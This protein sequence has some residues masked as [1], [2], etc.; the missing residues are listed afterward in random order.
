MHIFSN[1]RL[2]LWNFKLKKKNFAIQTKFP[3]HQHFCICSRLTNLSSIIPLNVDTV[4]RKLQVLNYNRQNLLIDL[5]KL[6]ITGH[7]MSANPDIF[8]HFQLYLLSYLHL[9]LKEFHPYFLETILC[10][11]VFESSFFYK[12][13][14]YRYC[15]FLIL[16][17]YLIPQFCI[18]WRDIKVVSTKFLLKFN[19]VLELSKIIKARF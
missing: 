15:R 9:F 8:W 5:E 4:W 7:G 12:L 1:H 17:E 11:V 14:M 10:Q 19:V 6:L 3:L 13:H 2:I 18:K 16:C